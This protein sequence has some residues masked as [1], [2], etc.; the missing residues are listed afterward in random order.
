MTALLRNIV[1]DFRKSVSTHTIAVT[2]T[3]SRDVYGDKV[4]IAQVLVNLISNAIKYSPQ[5]KKIVVH[6]R[7]LNG[8]CEVSVRDSG[9]GI[10][11]KDQREIFT[12]FFR[13]S[14]AEAG[15]IAGSGLGLFIARAIV[16]K[17]RGRIW[18]KSTVGRGST[19]YFTIALAQR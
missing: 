6:V 10:A 5:G 9:S 18:L 7:A 4:R 15:D 3:C 12:R 13:S 11:K 1:S 14:D 8:K 19:F 17:H 16:R 2:G